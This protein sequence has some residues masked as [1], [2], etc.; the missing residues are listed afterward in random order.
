MRGP[1]GGE[2]LEF[3]LNHR[4][5]SIRAEGA[6][7]LEVGTNLGEV[8]VVER[9]ADEFAIG[10]LSTLRIGAQGEVDRVGL[11]QVIRGAECVGLIARPPVAGGIVGHPGPHRIQ[12]DVSAAGE[13]IGFGV[14]QAGLVAA[15][16]ES[17]AALVGAVEG[18]GVVATE[19][20][21]Q[22]CD[23]AS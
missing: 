3:R 2:S 19:G 5:E 10:G 17:A 13:K 21:H 14:D 1:D 20:L 11:Q 8:D 4:L 9:L 18:L 15:L 12:F 7:L 23:G 6:L 22:A 16:P